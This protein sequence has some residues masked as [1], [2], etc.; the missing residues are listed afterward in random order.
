[1]IMSLVSLFFLNTPSQAALP[2]YY[3]RVN[4][5]TT[6]LESKELA[7]LLDA[8]TRIKSIQKVDGEE[9]MYALTTEG[10]AACSLT[11]ELEIVPPDS[12][13]PNVPPPVGPTKYKVAKHSMT[14]LPVGK[15]K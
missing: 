13:N 5:F 6:I 12:G 11:V 7:Q 10:P 4:Q 8:S 3:D 9:L 15:L 14:C 2:P 1:M